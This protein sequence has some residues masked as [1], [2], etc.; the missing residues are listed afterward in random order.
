MTGIGTYNK[1]PVFIYDRTEADV[2]RVKELASAGWDGMSKED[3]KAWLTGLKG[4][5][6]RSDMERLESNCAQIAE[7]LRLKIDTYAEEFP[8]YPDQDYFLHLL[9]NVAALRKSGYRYIET[10]EVPK[11]P[12]DTWQKM[13]DLEKILCDV[14]TV[15]SNHFKYYAGNEIYAG[16]TTGFL[17]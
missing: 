8:I 2:N 7:L 13:N 6:N 1:S 5:F 16:E 9:G 15:Y 14:Y 10:P 17:L 4:A 11:M 3:K 12:V